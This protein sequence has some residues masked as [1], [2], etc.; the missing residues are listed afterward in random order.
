M[1][2]GGRI[3][4]FACVGASIAALYIMLYLFFLHVGW[5]QWVANSIAFLLAVAVQYVG[6]AG[7]T[8]KAR[9]NDR[10][11]MFRF[12]VMIVFGL[13]TSAGITGL[14]APVMGLAD[15]LAAGIVTC[16]LPLQNYVILS[17]WV[18]ADRSAW[19]EPA[20]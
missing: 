3:I 8:F 11:Q 9:F 13:L 19:M 16:V 12:A 10:S 6:Q 7:I 14:L 17:R 4:R 5:A 18:F 2:R 1:H 20:K 15:W